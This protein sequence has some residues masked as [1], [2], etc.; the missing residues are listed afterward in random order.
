MTQ[1]VSHIPVDIAASSRPFRHHHGDPREPAAAAAAIHATR[2]G[3]QQQHHQP[4]KKV[5]DAIGYSERC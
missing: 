3:H 1:F 5:H 4:S 2:E